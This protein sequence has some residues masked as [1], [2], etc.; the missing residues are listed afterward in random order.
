VRRSLAVLESL[1][2]PFSG[3]LVLHDLDRLEA[4]QKPQ[5]RVIIVRF[6]AAQFLTNA[7]RGDWPE[8]LLRLQRSAA[9]NALGTGML[10][11]RELRLLRSA[12]QHCTGDWSVAGVACLLQSAAAARLRSHASGAL[13]IYRLAYEV[14]VRRGWWVEAA[15][16]ALEIASFGAMLGDAVTRT[17]WHRLAHLLARRHLLAATRP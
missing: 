2:E 10:L 16:A 8:H 17:A 14:A 7:L 9:L 11:D 15:T 4:D 12:L 6:L 1:H 13:A 5:A 3:E